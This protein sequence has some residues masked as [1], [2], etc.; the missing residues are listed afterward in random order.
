[1]HPTPRVPSTAALISCLALRAYLSSVKVL[2][3]QFAVAGEAAPNSLRGPEDLPPP[4]SRLCPNCPERCQRL[5]LSF[6]AQTLL[7]H[8]ATCRECCATQQQ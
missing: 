6:T 4:G 5:C 7:I 1:M 2:H 3:L 8:L